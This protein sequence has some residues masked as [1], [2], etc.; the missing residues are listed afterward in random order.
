MATVYLAQTLYFPHSVVALKI[1]HAHLLQDSAFLEMFLDEATIA[2]QIRHPNVCRVFDFGAAGEQHYIAMEYL[3][4]ESLASLWRRLTDP[5]V[6]RPEGKR[7]AELVGRILSDAC[8]GLHAA[9]E[10]TAENGEPLQVVHRDV[11]PENVMLTF[12]GEAKLLDFGVASAARQ[13]H[14]TRTGILKGKFAYIAPELLRGNKADRRTD[15]WGMGATA[16][17]LLTGKRL[18]HRA[19]DVDTLNAINEQRIVPPSELVPGIP[20]AMD[21]VVLSALSRNPDE[22]PENARALGS[23]LLRASATS[24]ETAGL[25]DLAEWIESLFPDGPH[26]TR[27]LIRSATADGAAISHADRRF[28]PPSPSLRSRPTRPERL[29]ANA[30]PI[31][32]EPFDADAATQ[33][34]PSARSVPLPLKRKLLR[35]YVPPAAALVAGVFLGLLFAHSPGVSLA[36]WGDGTA[37]VAPPA[38]SSHSPPLVHA[39]GTSVVSVEQDKHRLILRID[40]RTVEIHRSESQPDASSS[41]GSGPPEAPKATPV[42][43][44]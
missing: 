17:E 39:G 11:S 21:E 19:T 35:R 8:E 18:F 37:T 16:W 4:G 32:I 2:S 5:E 12:E 41:D 20:K 38:G 30:E 24:G 36:R 10:L 3:G 34:I 14:Q 22:R 7:M 28:G 9:H 31:E 33:F 44:R 26:R 1:V 6:T 13:H 25:G 40:G 15:V 42:A 29:S 23:A 43:G 27:E